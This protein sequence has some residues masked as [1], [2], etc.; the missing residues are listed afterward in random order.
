MRCGTMRRPMT[1][2]TLPLLLLLVLTTAG[3]V[4]VLLG[5]RDGP[6]V[7]DGIAG[8]PDAP[9]D[10]R[11][12][13]VAPGARTDPARA[14]APA[15]R[16]AGSAGRGDAGDPASRW[17]V[18]GTVVAAGSGTPLRGATVTAEAS[19]HPETLGGTEGPGP[20]G[21]ASP[22]TDAEGNFRLALD[23][24]PPTALTVRHPDGRPATV[25]V[26]GSALA[27]RI[28]LDAGY[29][30]TGRVVARGGAALEGAEVTVVPQVATAPEAGT[31]ADR[32]G[33]FAVRVDPKA[34]GTL[35]VAHPRH[36]TRRV[37]LDLKVE[38]ERVVELVPALVL[39]CRLRVA[40]A[41]RPDG[42]QALWSSGARSGQETLGLTGRMP[43]PAEAGP[44]AYGPLELP[45]DRAGT[46]MS[47][48][49]TAPGLRPATEELTPARP[50]GEERVIEVA[51]DRD[52]EAGAVAVTLEAPDGAPFPLPPDA[53]VAVERADGG[54]TP[55]FARAT[56]AAGALVVDGLAAGTYRVRVW[57]A[58][59]GP[60]EAEVAVVAGTTVGARAR[61][62]E[63]ARLRVR[64]TGT[65][66]RRAL[67]RIL[68]AGRPAQP[69][70]VDDPSGKARVERVAVSGVPS[71]VV[72]VGEE[73]VTF[74]GLP[75]GPHRVEVVSPD[76][77]APAVEAELRP[78]ETT[79]AE[80]VG[81]IR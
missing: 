71:V 79:A 65:G 54:P 22:T 56:D 67:V 21:L 75:G 19:R 29:L 33:R 25:V 78:G 35:R 50:D 70:V 18:S 30:V 58:G 32:D 53:V 23:A 20:A 13:A 44:D 6:G 81:T 1:R 16:G 76:V 15:A 26:D 49:L 27:L 38:G 14:D 5:R 64:V 3:V 72:V 60:A 36:V 10:P 47:R 57:P 62:T 31:T 41:V 42:V 77:S 48:R 46:P 2:R 59:F 34:P 45:L 24:G 9:A 11:P 66:G 80:V 4:V 61:A 37:A 28:E 43:R 17:V 69:R 74:G 40:G 63:E 7:E 55:S 51:M 12:A 52:P 8:D 68:S 39:W 73:G